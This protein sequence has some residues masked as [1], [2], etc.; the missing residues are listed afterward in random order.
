MDF[1]ASEITV[2]GV[3]YPE[4]LE[5]MTGRSTTGSLFDCHSAEAMK[6]MA[7]HDPPDM[8]NEP[9]ITPSLQLLTVPGRFAVCKLAAAS[10]IPTWATAGDFFSVT[11]TADELSVVCRSE[12][13]P[14]GITCERDW[15]CL[16]VAGAMPFTL[17]GVLA[18][19]T[20]PVARAGVGIFAISTFD[21]DYLLMKA[22]EVDQA[23][24]AWRAVGHVVVTD[25]R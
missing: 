8:T 7:T 22:T 13:V 10:P 23:I 15:C 25:E 6:A 4:K 5:Q 9:F 18:S 14:D 12:V 20:M 16:R 1:A 19:L 3:R 11:R 24:A 17:V 21:T 2:H